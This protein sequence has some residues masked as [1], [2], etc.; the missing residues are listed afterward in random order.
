VWR[1]PDQG[2]WEARGKPQH[3]HVSSKLM[4]W[5]A[6][7]RASMLAEIRGDPNMATTWRATADEIQADVLARGVSD[8]GVLRQHYETDAL[9]ASTLLAGSFK[10]LA[11]DDNRLRNTVL[12]VADE[13]TE[14][15]I[16]CHRRG[17]TAL[18]RANNAPGA[19]PT[20]PNGATDYRRGVS[21]WLAR[22][23]HTMRNSR[24]TGRHSLVG[25]TAR[26][27]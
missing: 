19:V 4:C 12:A 6:L 11:H 8:R 20:T 10:F 22:K 27:S 21:S 26:T 7:D 3:Y 23:Q 5:V 14:N 25:G 24:P 18:R 16:L 9:D 15:S 17:L 2:I 13:L 1:D